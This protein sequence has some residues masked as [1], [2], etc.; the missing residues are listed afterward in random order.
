M[1]YNSF[2]LIVSRYCA[3]IF[4]EKKTRTTLVEQK[5]NCKDA[6]HFI[7]VYLR[8]NPFGWNTCFEIVS[9]FRNQYVFPR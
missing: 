1:L 3:Q 5:E 8:G 2:Y 6:N 9:K 7:R 4:E